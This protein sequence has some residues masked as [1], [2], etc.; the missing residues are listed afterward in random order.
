M[1]D[2]LDPTHYD[3]QL[4]NAKIQELTDAKEFIELYISVV[5]HDIYAPI[6]FINIIGDNLNPQ[7]FT[8]KELLENFQLI[9]NSTKRLEL[10]CSNLLQLLTAQQSTNPLPTARISLHSKIQE[11][12]DFFAIGLI[13]KQIKFHNTVPKSLFIVT[14]EDALSAILSNLVSNAIRFTQL[15][16]I[17]VSCCFS[18]EQLQLTIADS[19]TGMPEE[20]KTQLNQKNYKIERKPAM[21]HRSY[22]F[23]YNLIFQLLQQIDGDIFIENN[24][25]KGTRVT[26]TLRNLS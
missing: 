13:T 17:E 2:A 20:I 25:P 8:K 16:T 10:L 11:I 21:E 6:K 9:I 1:S 18:N 24:E 7:Q 3:Y 15:G 22:G 5:N 23:G 4:L 19:G 26:V 14:N 12:Q